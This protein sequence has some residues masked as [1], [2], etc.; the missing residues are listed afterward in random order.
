MS[1][2]HPLVGVVSGEGR[3][4]K[5]LS[6]REIT[7]DHKV[8][9]DMF[10]VPCGRCIGCRLERSREWAIRC[11]H[12]AQGHED[13]C[14]ITLT[15]R[16]SCPIGGSRDL[17]R[18]LFKPD[19]QKFMKRLRKAIAPKKV[20]YFHVGE[21][22]EVCA[23]CGRPSLYTGAGQVCHC[24]KF[25]PSLG[26]PHHH[27]CLFGFDFPDKVLFTRRQGVYLYRSEMLERLWPYGYCTIGEV[28][29]ESAAYVARYVTKKITGEPAK[30]HYAG[31]EKEYNT[32]SRRPGIAARWF[33]EFSSDV[34]PK[35]F[36]V[37]KGKILKV[38]KFYDKKLEELNPA[39][40]EKI[41]RDRMVNAINNPD[42]CVAKRRAGE[43]ITE[44][45]FKQLSRSYEGG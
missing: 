19:F 27:A 30:E 32:M 36:V 20:R 29:F 34:F 31:R 39:K 40:Y 13:N 16:E 2:Y 44:Q 11:Y 14:F 28:T 24:L 23:D 22:G 45:R 3:L 43:V 37:I 38:P 35:D 33:E 18:S 5:V 12:E 9:G 15:F 26:R 21:Y 7:D 8:R 10:P 41:K 42:A 25:K 6:R 17:T 1:C 4:V